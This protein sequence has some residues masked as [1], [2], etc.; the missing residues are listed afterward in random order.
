MDIF[1]KCQGG[2]AQAREARER[3][4][5]PYFIPLTNNEGTA[6]LIGARH[7]I[8][9][10]SNN[11]L[12]L[13]MHP[14]GRQAAIDAIKQY[15]PSCSGSR[16]LNGTL[17]LHLE[18]ERRLA[19][20]VGKEAA[21]VF[22]T[23]YQVN[24]GT[25]SSVV[26]RDD[27]VITDKE[28]HAS[29]V[30]GCRLSYGQM[31]RFIHNDL[32]SLEQVLASVPDEA[33]RLVVVDGVFSMGG[34]IAPLP[35]SNAMAALAARDIME[36]EPEHVERLW[37]NAHFMMKGFRELGFNIGNT[38]TPIIPVIIGED[39]TC[40]RFWKEL[41]DRGVYTNPV[42][43]PAVPEGMA[44][45]RTSYMATHTREQL[46]RALDIFEQ[47]GKQFGII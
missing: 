31:K 12:G 16:F 38:Q 10:G 24:V 7:M 30:D 47:A 17:E 4:L 36:N 28:D 15:G 25:L 18:L 2:F 5:Y 20:W 43:S 45:L 19:R 11:Y 9:I 41:F 39:E 37:D 8:M 33:G 44:L 22:S 13:P 34:E 46:Q 14:K 35:A 6:S 3:G 27:Y 26:T 42:I 40:F 21:V 29:I 32:E 1:K 23:G